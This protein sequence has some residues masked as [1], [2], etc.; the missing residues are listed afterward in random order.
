MAN[1]SASSEKMT[2]KKAL[3]FV[4]TNFAD[5]LPVDVAEKLENM[6]VQLEKRSTS[7]R[8]PSARQVENEVLMAKTFEHMQ[9]DRW[10]AVDEMVK[11][12]DFYPSDI[13]PQ[14]VSAL[15][16]KLVKS[17]SVERKVDKRKVYFCKIGA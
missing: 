13:T 10:Y 14:R 1:I 11:E 5:T 15:M 3:D 12:F 7:E 2:N 17:G 16:T 9:T 4:L 8:K 6:V